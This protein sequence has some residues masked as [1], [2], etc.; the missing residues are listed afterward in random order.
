MEGRKEEMVRL[1]GV[2]DR[3]DWRGDG[4]EGQWRDGAGGGDDGGRAGGGREDGTGGRT[5]G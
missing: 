2:L 4:R 5:L 3:A 1:D